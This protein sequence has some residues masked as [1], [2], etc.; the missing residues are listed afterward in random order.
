MA[1]VRAD[2]AACAGGLARCLLGCCSDHRRVLG[3][4]HVAQAAQALRK[5]CALRGVRCLALHQLGQRLLV[6]EEGR[7]AL[8]H[9]EGLHRGGL[10]HVVCNAVKPLSVADAVSVA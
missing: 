9:H 3:L 4:W 1:V 10:Y 6:K 7:R 2:L 8:G 5:A